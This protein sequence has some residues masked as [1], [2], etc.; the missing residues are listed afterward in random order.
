MSLSEV[1]VES[2][3]AETAPL[4]ARH[5]AAV[6]ESVPQR[7]RL[8]ALLALAPALA[9]V[10]NAVVVVDDEVAAAFPGAVEARAAERLAQRARAVF[11]REVFDPPNYVARVGARGQGRLALRFVSSEEANLAGARA[12]ATLCGWALDAAELARLP[13]T[14][15]DRAATLSHV[16]QLVRGALRTR[17]R[18]A[19]L[20]V[21]VDEPAQVGGERREALALGLRRV[22]RATDHVGYLGSDAFA[23]L[24]ALDSHEIEAFVAAQRV[25]A[26]TGERWRAHVGVAVY[27]EDGAQVDDL[28]EKASAAALAAMSARSRLPYW[29]REDTGRQ[30]RRQVAAHAQMRDVADAQA[31]QLRCRPV[32][33]AFSGAVCAVLAEPGLPT[34]S[35]EVVDPSVDGGLRDA[36]DRWAVCAAAELQPS[37]AAARV[38]LR[39]GAVTPELIEAVVARFGARERARH[40]AIALRGA[41]LDALA[42]AVPAL[43]RLRSLGVAIGLDALHAGALAARGEIGV[44]LDF[45]TIGNGTDVGSLAALACGAILAPQVVA[46]EVGSLDVAR[47][48]GRHGATALGGPGLAAD[49][50]AAEIASLAGARLAL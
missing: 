34:G 29:F 49:V 12:L 13:S 50:P 27:P 15:G 18:F 43:R 20:Y 45:V 11:E 42:A 22:V 44:D 6:V 1:R 2:E 38:Y 26:A 16:E 30:L 9:G 10:R 17:R 28:L 33:D 19:V 14:V 47:W 31:L 35:G 23:V 37:S 32:F 40:L 25:L 21:D 3:G 41:D 36:L 4:S 39:V 7:E 48:L 5:V 8:R 24:V 46:L